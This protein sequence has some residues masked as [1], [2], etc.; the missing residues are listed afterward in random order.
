MMGTNLSPRFDTFGHA[1]PKI[2]KNLLESFPAIADLQMVQPAV[3]F[4]AQ[5]FSALTRNCLPSTLEQGDLDCGSRL[6]ENTTA[7]AM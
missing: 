5:S 7:K 4:E 3:S 2:L 1:L 6:R